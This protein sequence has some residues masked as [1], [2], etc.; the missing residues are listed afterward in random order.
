MSRCFRVLPVTV[1]ASLCLSSVALAQTPKIEINSDTPAFQA[2]QLQAG[3]VSVK[4]DYEPYKLGEGSSDTDK[5]LRY[6]IAYDGVVKVNA[7]E[8]T[9]Y[10]GQIS[11]Q[12]MDGD[13]TPEVIVG[14]FSG[15]AHCCTNFKIY[16]WK[17]N[18]FLSTETGLRDGN[19]GS[20][21]DLDGNGT[22]EFATYDN[23][24]L[25]AFS[26]YAGSFPPSQ[27][28]NLRNGKLAE[29]TRQYPKHLRRTLQDMFKS[30]QER[31]GNSD[32]EING[33]LAGY[34]A[35]KALVGEF[36]QG[37]SFMLANYDRKSDWGLTIYKGDR[38]VGQYPNFPTALRAFLQQRGYIKR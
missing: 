17:K 11:L 8:Q 28:F 32:A 9:L 37:W 33:V 38:E 5:N 26:S 20:F 23:A 25:Y 35:Q 3:N 21:M 15:G 14:T 29:T 4:V 12:D 7:G 6:Q 36:Q 10:T 13:R 2:R 31:K 24:F 16:S 27:V 18:Q 1:L 22:L 30:I 19:G 34:V